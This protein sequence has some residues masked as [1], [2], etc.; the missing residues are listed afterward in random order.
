[1]EA[2]ATKQSQHARQGYQRPCWIKR[3]GL[4]IILMQAGRAAHLGVVGNLINQLLLC[5]VEG[6]SDGWI[7]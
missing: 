1:M 4:T 7:L 6:A 3:E 5:V 2:C